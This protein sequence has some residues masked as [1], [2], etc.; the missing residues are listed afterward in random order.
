MKEDF[1]ESV[2]FD[3][4]EVIRPVLGQGK[5]AI[6][7]VSMEV[8]GDETANKFVSPQ[9]KKTEVAGGDAKKDAT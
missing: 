8:K 4:K 3:E 1:D 9:D 2:D 7:K 6:V 5:P